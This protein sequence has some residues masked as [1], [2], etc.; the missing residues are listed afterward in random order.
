[1]W[2]HSKVSMILVVGKIGFLLMRG[3]KNSNALAE[4]KRQ[5]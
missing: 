1:M 3:A 5:A 4:E 2:I